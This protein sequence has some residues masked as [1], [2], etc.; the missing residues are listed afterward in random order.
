LRSCNFRVSEMGAIA[1]KCLYP[2]RK[3]NL[4]ELQYGT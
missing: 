3:D 1:P 4:S 2:H